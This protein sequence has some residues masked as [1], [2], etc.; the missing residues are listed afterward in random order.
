MPY[1]SSNSVTRAQRTSGR[2][3]DDDGGRNELTIKDV[4]P[5]TQRKLVFSVDCD[6]APRVRGKGY[7]SILQSA[8]LS[9]AE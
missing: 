5:R 2:C 7:V 8:A 1:R 3:E 9:C 6:V 4:K